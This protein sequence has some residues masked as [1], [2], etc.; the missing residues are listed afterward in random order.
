MK[1]T[2]TKFSLVLIFS[3]FFLFGCGAKDDPNTDNDPTVPKPEVEDKNL[4]GL[5]SDSNLQSC[6]DALAA[7]NQW[8][9]SAQVTGALDC[10][11]K[12]IVS[13]AGLEYLINLTELYLSYNQITDVEPISK[14]TKLKVVR[15]QNNAIGSNGKGY[16][17]SLTTLSD[18]IDIN[19]AG[20]LTVS[21][22]ELGILTNQLNGSEDPTI[23]EGS[24]TAYEIVNPEPFDKVNCTSI[25]TL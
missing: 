9:S 17:D 7:S 14:L 24:L 19:I 4:A 11:K 21:C 6:V 5:F 15:L 20:N 25:D 8:V 22:T 3:S 16:V 23:L 13:L 1:I 10:S 18:A 2:V 12:N